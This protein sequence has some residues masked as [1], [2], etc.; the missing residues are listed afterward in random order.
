[1]DGIRLAFFPD[2]YHEVDGV[3]NTSRQ[4]EAFAKRCGF[5]ILVVCGGF[6]DKVEAEG[7]GTRI[8]CRRGRIAFQ[9][10]KRHDFDLLFWRYYQYIESAVRK[11]NPDVVHIT[12]PSDVGLVGALVAH[13]LKIPLAASWHT[14]LHEYAEKRALPLL[15]F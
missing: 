10:D 5:P 7:S 8:M 11:F 15:R 6:F 14:N 3:A 4:L 12:G 9:L 2:T 13:R 1:M